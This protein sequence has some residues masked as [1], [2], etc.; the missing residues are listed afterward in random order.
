MPDAREDLTVGL[1][2][3]A[4]WNVSMVGKNLTNRVIRMYGA[5]LPTSDVEHMASAMRHAQVR[6]LDSPYGHIATVLPPGTPEFAFFYSP[7]RAFLDSLS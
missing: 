7:T 4:G 6:T 1:G 5:A 3:I 2:S